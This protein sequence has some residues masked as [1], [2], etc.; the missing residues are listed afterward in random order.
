[1]LYDA[2]YNGR[3][4]FDD[5]YIEEIPEEVKG[6][7]AWFKEFLDKYY[8]EIAEKDLETDLYNSL[9]HDALNEYYN[10]DDEMKGDE[11]IEAMKK[12]KA[13]NMYQFLKEKKDKLYL[14]KEDKIATPL[15][16]AQAVIE[17]M[18]GSDT[19]TE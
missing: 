3:L 15:L 5:N 1:M 8:I 7:V 19:D 9:L 2:S 11:V 16:D 13:V 6:A 4:F 14:L 17:E 10:P 12:R 18:Y